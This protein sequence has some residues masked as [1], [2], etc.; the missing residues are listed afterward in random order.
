M[1]ERMT[2]PG[3]NISYRVRQQQYTGLFKVDRVVNKSAWETVATVNT[4]QEAETILDRL[5]AM[6]EM[7]CEQVHGKSSNEMF[8]QSIPAPENWRDE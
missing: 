2:Q 1:G 5:R 6:E 4:L 7:S 8:A 3:T